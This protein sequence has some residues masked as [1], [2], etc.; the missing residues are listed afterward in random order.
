MNRDALQ[1][2]F[3]IEVEQV[4]P[5]KVMYNCKSINVSIFKILFKN[6][7]FLNFKLHLNTEKKQTK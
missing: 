1:R 4:H 7:L 2:S 3:N 6:S 5:D